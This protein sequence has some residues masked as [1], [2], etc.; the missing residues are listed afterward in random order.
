MT[1]HFARPQRTASSQRVAELLRLCREDYL[2]AAASRISRS[3]TTPTVTPSSLPTA[4]TDLFAA[5]AEALDVPLASTDPDDE[6]ARN[7]LLDLRSSHVRILLESLASHPEV[8][9][10]KDAADVRQYTERTPVTYTTWAD[11]KARR[12]AETGEGQ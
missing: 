5:I 8:P 10:D 12:A 7:V 3:D 9:L 1:D 2:S 11:V 6:L 4:V